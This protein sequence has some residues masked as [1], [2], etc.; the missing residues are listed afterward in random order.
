MRIRKVVRSL[1]CNRSSLSLSIQTVDP[2]FLPPFL[3]PNGKPHRWVHFGTQRRSEPETGDIGV[4]VSISNCHIYACMYVYRQVYTCRYVPC[5]SWSRKYMLHV[6]TVPCSKVRTGRSALHPRS[7]MQY[8]E[9]I[10]LPA[11]QSAGTPA[12]KRWGGGVGRNVFFFL[13]APS[14]HSNPETTACAPEIHV[15]RSVWTALFPVAIGWNT[16]TVKS[17]PSHAAFHRRPTRRPTGSSVKDSN[18]A[19]TSPYL[20]ISQLVLLGDR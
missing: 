13:S 11:I 6:D 18:P 15:G 19:R 17:P 7:D 9:H 4:V 2:P 14:I 16:P 10:S 3:P 1:I 12:C 20:T 8:T 5:T